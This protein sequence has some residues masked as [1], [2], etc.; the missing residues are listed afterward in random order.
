MAEKYHSHRTQ[1]FCMSQFPILFFLKVPLTGH[2][3]GMPFIISSGILLAIYSFLFYRGL[4]HGLAGAGGVLVTT[5]NPIMAYSIGMILNKK[6]P[7]RNEKTGLFLGLLAG[8]ILLKIWSQAGGILDTG[9]LF[10]LAAAFTWALMSKITSKAGY[11]GSS[12]SFTLWQYITTLLFILPFINVN[13]F[14][15]IFFYPR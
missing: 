15:T 8:C 2:R 13:E 3:K 1:E 9:N 7:S 11:F 14:L 6:L 12:L 4:K 5:L 10:F